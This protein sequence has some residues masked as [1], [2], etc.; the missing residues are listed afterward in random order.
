MVVGSYRS[1]RLRSGSGTL[2]LLVAGWRRGAQL[3]LAATL[4]RRQFSR[5][6][7]LRGEWRRCSRV[8]CGHVRET[9][10]RAPSC[11]LLTRVARA[12]ISGPANVAWRND[13][14]RR[15]DW[16]CPSA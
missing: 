5:G 15:T 12:R 13:L 10:G 8:A 14:V 6:M 3:L 2:D 1:V 4:E 16:T 11:H 9:L 7:Q